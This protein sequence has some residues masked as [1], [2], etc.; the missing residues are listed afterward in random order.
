MGVAALLPALRLVGKERVVYGA[1]C[2]VACSTEQTMEENRRNILG[3][4]GLT[5]KEREAIGHNIK[6]LFP[7]AVRRMK[8]LANGCAR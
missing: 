8:G 7:E 2:G 5:R 4:E 1:D 3:F 6:V